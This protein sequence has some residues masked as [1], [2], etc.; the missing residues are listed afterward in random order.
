MGRR[1][2]GT[3][4]ST[5]RSIGE[6][7][8]ERPGVFSSV[9]LAVVALNLVL[10]PAVLSLA[11]KPWDLFSFNPWLHNIPAWFVSNAEPLGQ[12]LDFLYNVALFWFVASSPSDAPEWGFTATTADVVRW[13]VMG[14]LWGA[15]F[16]LW[17]H[18]R[19]RLRVGG[20]G[21][22]SAA[23]G[24]VAGA[25]LTTVGFSTMPCSVAGCGAPVLPVLALALTGLSS[26]T[27]AWIDGVSRAVTAIVVLGVIA[28][29]AYLG[30]LVRPSVEDA[31]RTPP[32][33]R[34]SA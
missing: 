18:L 23:R 4:G 15:Y 5:L 31:G 21:G 28:G 29:V 19:R 33:G 25:L 7:I 10:P 13:A 17:L 2:L 16:T 32:I 12:K 3:V 24:G 20:A 26:V 34:R 11:R 30:W 1:I 14:I 27:L 8:R 22:R 9:A 6:A